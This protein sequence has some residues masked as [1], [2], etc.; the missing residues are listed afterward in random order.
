ME[1]T[2]N[3]KVSNLILNIYKSNV[4][5]VVAQSPKTRNTYISIVVANNA[6]LCSCTRALQ[7]ENDT[8]PFSHM[9]NQ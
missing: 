6:C 3:A 9:N 4:M 8:F 2:T 7:E 5:V 1:F